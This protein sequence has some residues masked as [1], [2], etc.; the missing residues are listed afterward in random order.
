MKTIVKIILA[1]VILL[2][3]TLGAGETENGSWSPAMTI[4]CLAA[5]WAAG[6][7]W[8]RIDKSQTNKS[9]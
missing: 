5:I 3:I 1:L 7:I 4:S 2:A 8:K 6:Y 9:L